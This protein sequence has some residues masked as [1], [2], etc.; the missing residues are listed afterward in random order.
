[1]N[2]GCTTA[3][4]P[5]RPPGERDEVAVELLDA[6]LLQIAGAAPPLLEAG[7]VLLGAQ[8]LEDVERAGREVGVPERGA[9]ARH[10]DRLLRSDPVTV[11]LAPQE[12]DPVL[13]LV[14]DLAEERAEQ[15]RHAGARRPAQS[16]LGG[17]RPA[18]H[19]DLAADGGGDCSRGPWLHARRR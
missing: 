12:W 3:S 17:E 9:A 13:E 5:S 2:P 16:S 19:V 7:Q 8:Q 18:A 10:H 14:A 4:G 15:E 11:Q 1:M 6:E